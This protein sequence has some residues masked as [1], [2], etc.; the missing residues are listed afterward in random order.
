MLFILLMA[1]LCFQGQSSMSQDPSEIIRTL[2]S[3]LFC[4]KKI[5]MNSI[6]FN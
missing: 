3:G 6:Y 5:Q 4:E 1:K 2:F